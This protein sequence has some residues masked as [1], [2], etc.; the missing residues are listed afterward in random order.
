MQYVDW[1]QTRYLFV[2]PSVKTLL[3]D[4]VAI[5]SEDILPQDPTRIPQGPHGPLQIPAGAIPKSRR[6]GSQLAAA[7]LAQ[8]AKSSKKT[9]RSRNL[10]TADNLSSLSKNTG[11]LANPIDLDGGSVMTLDEDRMLLSEPAR[12]AR[13]PTPPLSVPS[14]PLTPYHPGT[15]A[16]LPTMPAPTYATPKASMSL[17]KAFREVQRLQDKHLKDGT[18]WELGWYLDQEH[19]ESSDNLY[20]WIIHMHSFPLSIPLGRDMQDTGINAITFELR[21]SANYPFAPP[22]LRVIRPR[23]LP[24]HLGGGGHVTAGGSVCMDLLTSSGWMAA[25]SIDSILLQV[26]MAL[27]S[28][29]PRPARLQCA[30]D[31]KGGRYTHN[32]GA[33]GVYGEAEAVE[34]FERACRMHGW[35][36]PAEIRKMMS[37]QA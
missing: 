22:F 21:F 14:T 12:Q 13:P 18:L 24:F 5:N 2:Q 1:I 32:D 4:D 34:A 37:P 3:A 28:T 31:A 25:Y 26:R 33:G 19:F 9:T 36:V 11:T 30:V 29:D 6:P 10:L 23:F 35:E 27:M 8:G 15:I 7:T 20:Q 16:N 17:Q